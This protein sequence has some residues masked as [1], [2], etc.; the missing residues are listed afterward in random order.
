MKGAGKRLLLNDSWM[1][2]VA[3]VLEELLPS[4]TIQGSGQGGPSYKSPD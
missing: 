3:L 2:E 4:L 1:R